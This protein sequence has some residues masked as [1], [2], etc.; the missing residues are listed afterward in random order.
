MSELLRRDGYTVV[1]GDIGLQDVHISYDDAQE[2][3]KYIMSEFFGRTPVRTPVA[4]DKQ[5]KTLFGKGFNPQHRVY[6]D[7]GDPSVFFGAMI[8]HTC[9]E[10]WRLRVLMTRSS[11]SPYNGQP[12]R[13][14]ACYG[15]E[16]IGGDVIEAVKQT[17]VVRSIGDISIAYIE[18]GT[19]IGM[20]R[21]M[22]ERPMTPD[23]CARII[24]AAQRVLRRMNV[25]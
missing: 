19:D 14:E 13:S 6:G 1:G 4:D 22:F 21:K 9:L 7:D 11:R 10:S 3:K 8:K 15:I 12:Q 18:Q 5:D 23:D 2:A 24:Q 25:E 20:E 17:R 16:V